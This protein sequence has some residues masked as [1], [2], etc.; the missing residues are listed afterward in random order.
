VTILVF[1]AAGIFPAGWVAAYAAPVVLLAA[2]A[3]IGMGAAGGVARERQ[4]NTLT[5]LFM[6]PGG[7]RE[8]LRAKLVGATWA[9]RWFL[10]AVAGLLLVSPLGGT[11]VV[12]VPLLALAAVAY[13]AFAG[14]LGLWL[15]VRSRN[16]LTAHA[17]WMGFVA[18]S[19]IGTYLLADAMSR[20]VPVSGSSGASGAATMTVYPDWSRVANPV[21]A[22]QELAMSPDDPPG[23]YNGLRPWKPRWAPDQPPNL[24]L[25]LAGVAAHGLAAAVLWWLA[26]RRFDREGREE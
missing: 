16:A 20:R 23:G 12:A 24:M 5:D 6:L 22:W 3:S 14:A 4:R 18:L 26:L 1:L 9:G 21:M 17:S 2:A 7:R 25:P 8:I 10:L 11:P 15:S 19:L 13:L